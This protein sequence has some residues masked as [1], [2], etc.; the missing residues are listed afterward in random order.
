MAARWRRIAPPYYAAI[1]LYL[2]IPAVAVLLGR[3]GQMAGVL[4]FR[5]VSL[6]ALFLH[7]LFGDTINAINTPFWSLSLEFQF[8]LVLPLLLAT[9]ARFGA[10]TMI[11]GVAAASIAFRSVVLSYF[12]DHGHLINGFLLGRLTEFALGIGVALWYDARGQRPSPRRAPLALAAAVALFVAGLLATKTHG[13]LVDDIAFG[14]AYASLLIAVLAG[15][16][17]SSRFRLI[18]EQPVLV[19]VGMISYSLYLCHRL[20]MERSIQAYR[21]ATR[22]PKTP[23]DLARIF[24]P[25]SE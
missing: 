1:V 20:V 25:N 7:G 5:Q 13:E 19:W 9:V 11:L 23:A 21:A 3:A 18:F 10:T 22:L 24:H 17:H 6:H 16:R 2:M 14:L 12:R 8:Y 4:T 15:V